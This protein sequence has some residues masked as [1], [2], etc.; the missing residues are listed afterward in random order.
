M[1]S[2][3]CPGLNQQDGI[4]LDSSR[5]YE[6]ESDIYNSREVTLGMKPVLERL[7]HSLSSLGGSY[8]KRI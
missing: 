8:I 1:K 6:I 4:F 7:S 3:G 5:I 2:T